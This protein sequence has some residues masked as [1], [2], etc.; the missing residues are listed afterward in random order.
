V[1]ALPKLVHLDCRPIV[2]GKLGESLEVRDIPLMVIEGS[3]QKQ[4]EKKQSGN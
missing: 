3:K 4:E 2:N 1:S